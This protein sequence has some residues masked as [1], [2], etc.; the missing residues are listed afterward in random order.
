[1]NVSG[2]DFVLHNG[3][4]IGEA[5]QV[6]MV[7]NEERTPKAPEETAVLLEE[8]VVSAERPI[9]ELVLEE[10][11]NDAHIQVV[12]YNLRQELDLD[13][14]TGAMNFIRDRRVA[15]IDRLQR[16][17]EAAQAG[18]PVGNQLATCRQLAGN[19]SA[20]VGNLLATHRPSERIYNSSRTW[21]SCLQWRS[22]G[23]RYRSHENQR[24]RN[25][26][27]L[28]DPSNA[29]VS[30]WNCRINMKDNV[31][32]L[33]SSEDVGIMKPCNASW[34]S[35]REDFIQKMWCSLNQYRTV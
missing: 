18:E 22:I 10:S 7:D 21:L 15:H 30:C 12:I 5:E 17:D 24:Q 6:K 8:A 29:Y 31:F 11:C 34:E 25:Q 3:E 16:C 27:Y 20:M 9:Q 4:F 28:D 2:S 26:L 13:Q 33:F 14:Q 32:I 19:L 35:K 1:M 23:R